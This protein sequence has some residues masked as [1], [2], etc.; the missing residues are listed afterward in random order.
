MPPSPSCSFS[1]FY[2]ILSS[3]ITPA[4]SSTLMPITGDVRQRLFKINVK[5][6]GMEEK[7]K[8]GDGGMVDAD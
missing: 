7:D 8:H 3:L 5:A 4:L 6:A 1:G 2:S